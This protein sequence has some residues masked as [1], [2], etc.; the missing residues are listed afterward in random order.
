MHNLDRANNCVEFRSKWGS[1]SW[2]QAPGL[3]KGTEIGVIAGYSNWVLQSYRAESLAVVSGVK[4]GDL[5]FH[6]DGS[7]LVIPSD[8]GIHFVSSLEMTWNP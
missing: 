1:K 8:P 7:C 6:S 4:I 3:Q 2:W 5:S